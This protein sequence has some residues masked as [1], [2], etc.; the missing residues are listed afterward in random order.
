MSNILKN[1]NPEQK[2]AAAHD[3]GPLLII[4]GA[5]TGK[6]KVITTRIAHLIDKKKA[7]PEEILALTFTEKAAQEMEERVDLLLPY[8]VINTWI[9]TFHAFG[10]RIMRDHAPLFGLNPDFKILNSAEQ[11]LFIRDNLFKL[12]LKHL[13]P[14][15]NPTKFIETIIKIISRAKDENVS[16][17]EY[18]NYVKNQ[19]PKVKN[20]EEKKKIEIQAEIAHIYDEYQ[21]LM[22]KNNYLDFGDQVFLLYRR[23]LKNPALL[24]TLRDQFK[25][26]L[27]DEFQDTNFI[28]NELIKLLAYPKNN[29]TVVG[30]DDQ[31]I[32]KFRGAAISNILQF[33]KDFPKTNETVLTQNFRSTQPILDS[34]YELIKNNNPDRLEVKSKI[35]KKLTSTTKKKGK[36]Q[37]LSYDTESSEAD[38]VTTIIEERIKKGGSLKDFAILLRANAAAGPFIKSLNLK[39][40]PTQ[41]SGDTLIYRRPEIQL[42]LSFLRSLSSNQD[43]LSLYALATSEIYNIDV[44]DLIDIVDLCR[45][46]NRSLFRL[47]KDLPSL[48]QYVT[49]SEETKDKAKKLISDIEKYRERSVKKT[50]GVILYEFLSDKG[51]LKEFSTTDSAEDEIKVRNIAYFF[52]Q[53]K[54]FEEIVKSPTLMHLTEYLDSLLESGAAP[55]E[56]ELDPDIDAVNVMTAHAAKGLEFKTVFISSLVDGRFPTISRNDF[57]D[58]PDEFIKEVLP[59]GDWHIGEERR[60]FYVAITRAKENLYLTSARDYG[61]TR[62]R[63]PSPFIAEALGKKVIQEAKSKTLK[64]VEQIELFREDKQIPV[65]IKKPKSL[66]LSFRQVDDYLTCPLKYKYSTILRI[67]VMQHFAVSFGNA[68]H[69]TI[70]WYYKEREKKNN[71]SFEDIYKKFKF[72]WQNEGYL[73][74]DH[75]KRALKEGRVMLKRFYN[76]T[77]NEEPPLKIEE[78]FSVRVGEDQV[79]GRIDAI[80]DEDGKRRIIDFKSSTIDSS[81]QAKQRVTGSLQLGIYAL[82]YKEMYGDLPDSVGLHFLGSGIVGESKPT[83]GRLETV[84]KKIG[85]ARKGIIAQEFDPEPSKFNCTYCAFSKICPYSE[86]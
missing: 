54:T 66:R 60:L 47:L 17:K 20:K 48:E 33:K 7:K 23:L 44:N 40:I 28:Q 11:V 86:A 36:I 1:L 38:E 75:Q 51:I 4:A 22:R 83:E 37:Y 63:K 70:S 79:T 76:K 52:K 21:G 2:K 31:S 25:Y 8:G 67:P 82:A 43:N 85:E 62:A 24:K 53:I 41:F 58:I 77:K 3:E 9:S 14:P 57:L 74:K 39:G 56:R 64:K 49:V 19:K 73:S 5:G 35:N 61:G 6:T 34:A 69:Q 78:G 68:I 84:K 81:V 45:R 16:A 27:V 46:Q 71:P 80:Y 55:E 26:I 13:R 15:T 59:E 10:D 42:L 72:H 12:K 32:Y 65:K 18:L 30:D 50:P 29:I